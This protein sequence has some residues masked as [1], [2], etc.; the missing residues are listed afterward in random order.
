MVN[1]RLASSLIILG[2]A[3]LSLIM[4]IMVQAQSD[5]N[6]PLPDQPAVVPEGTGA[7]GAPSG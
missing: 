4:V 3:F 5:D 7:G 2:F 1:R 6:P